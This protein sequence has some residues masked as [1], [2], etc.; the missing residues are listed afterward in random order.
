MEFSASAPCKAILFGEHYVVYGSPALSLAIEP[1]NAVKFSDGAKGVN[2]KSALGEGRISGG[3]RYIGQRE[4]SLYAEVARA[5]LGVGKMPDCTAEFLPAWK[6]KGVGTSASLSAAFAAG[7]YRLKGENA[8]AEMIFAA[9]QAGDLVAHGG[10]ASGIDAKTVSHGTALVF[11]RSFSPLAFNSSEA[12]FALPDGT[13][14]LLI[15]TNVGKKDGTDRMLEIFA[16]QFGIRVP[17]H[18]AKEE[19]RQKISKEYAPLWEKIESAMKGTDAETLG[20][21]MDENHLLLKKRKMSSNGIEK[22]VS[23]AI[24]AGAYGAKMTGGGGEGGAALALFD[25]GSIGAAAG[26]ITGKTGFACHI[27]SLA[28][29]GACV[30]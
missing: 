24:A 7:L 26:K 27:I 8:D 29:K 20:S 12:V 6:L 30:D 4:I 23:S 11:Q 10:R 3:G 22:A 2:L 25:R 13:A 15:D 1:R 5:V 17:P 18:E 16:S 14:L 19:Q 28:K 21:L 9:A